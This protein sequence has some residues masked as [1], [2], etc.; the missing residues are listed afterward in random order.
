M[1]TTTGITAAIA[2]SGLLCGLVFGT[3]AADPGAPAPN[4]GSAAAAAPAG[5]P[6][7]HPLT[8]DADPARTGEVVH[9]GLHHGQEGLG[10]V[11]SE[12]FA[13]D[14][15]NSFDPDRGDARVVRDENG[16]AE[17]TAKIADVRP[18]EYT[19]STRIGG[20]SGPQI[21]ITVR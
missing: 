16:Y 1:R 8:V 18:G 7:D 9:I 4:T 10:Y 20:G 2:T 17:L 6:S 21:P 13:H 11:A 3:A 19:I 14:P 12:A 5:M 15:Q